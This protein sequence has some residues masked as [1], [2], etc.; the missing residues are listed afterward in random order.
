MF[1][2]N[3]HFEIWINNYFLCLVSKL[4]S[5]LLDDV[6]GRWQSRKLQESP[7]H[8]TVIELVGTMSPFMGWGSF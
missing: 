8:Q 4:K 5:A 7:L 2:K 6:T 3:M 1:D